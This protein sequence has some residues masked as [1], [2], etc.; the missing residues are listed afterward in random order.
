VARTSQLTRS[1]RIDRDV[2]E[3]L[4]RLAK[5]SDVSVNALSSRAIRRYAEWDSFAEKFGFVDLPGAIVG[6]MM[7]QLTEDQ[8][9]EVGAWVGGSLLRE[10]VTFWFKQIT[11][12]TVLNACPRLIAKYGRLFEF[13]EHDDGGRRT[14][15]FKHEGGQKL[16]TF[17]EQ[18]ITT[19]FAELL[20]KSVTVE[21]SENQ[22]V[23]RFGVP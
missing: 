11:L 2:D 18:V 21:R 19:A 7:R 13:E 22:V 5:E 1:V 17:Y 9:R 12:E 16:S 15:V 20:H 4:R 8:L 6:R 14:I 3:G 10:Y 23:A